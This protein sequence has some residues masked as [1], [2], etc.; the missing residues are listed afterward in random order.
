MTSAATNLTTIV[1]DSVS[2]WSPAARDTR[3]LHE[4][5]V[6]TSAVVEPTSV[7]IPNA[8]AVEA[9][10]QCTAPGPG[11]MPALDGMVSYIAQET[12]KTTGVTNK[13]YT[14]N[15]KHYHVIETYSPLIYQKIERETPWDR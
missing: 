13:F 15:R 7:P 5:F 14:T 11:L 1:A 9:E 6:G 12:S 4:I 3:D 2:V 10:L 8:D